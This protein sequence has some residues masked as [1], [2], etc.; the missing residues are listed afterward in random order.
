LSAL[1]IRMIYFAGFKTTVKSRLVV[2]SFANSPV[3][4]TNTPFAP[5]LQTK[6]RQ[7]EVTLWCMG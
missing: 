6:I 3:I 7:F 4:T 2:Q 1:L 5:V